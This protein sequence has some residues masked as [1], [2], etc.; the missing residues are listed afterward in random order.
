MAAQIPTTAR[1]Y[2][3]PALGSYT[4]LTLQTTPLPALKST[5]VLVKIHAVS[6]Q[7]RDLMIALNRY[8]HGNLPENLV[9][10]SDMAGEVV[11]VG[12]DVTRW[13]VGDRVCANFATDHLDGDV[14]A[15]TTKSALGGGQ[16][17]VLT[18]YRSFPDN[19][20][21]K[22]PGHLSFEEAST[23]PCAALTAYN[24]LM[25]PKPVKA[26]DTVLVL[27]TGGVSIF[28]LQFAV[29]SGANVIAT[30]SSDDKLEIAKK[31]GATHT[32]NYNTTPDWDKGRR[33]VDHILEVGG[34]G[35][36][37]KSLASVRYAGYI[38]IIGSVSKN[39]STLTSVIGPCIGKAI[40]LRGIRVGS[41]AQFESMNRLLRARPEP[42]RPAVDRVFSFEE[43]V[44]AY[45]Y[46]ESQ[47]HVGKVV[48]RRIPGYGFAR[49]VMVLM[50]NGVNPET[51]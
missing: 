44:D 26:G 19:S 25:G 1:S 35:T 30:S 3:F 47:K 40:I 36:F 6:L 7:F 50:W 12:S 14:N 24:A 8:S 45:A 37:E 43:A 33:G 38:H 27:G 11:A 39:A 31:L 16:H 2:Y 34:P 20:L 13:E 9:P 5:Y 46:L 10:C 29:A 51:E 4:N 28:G 22:I 21:V 49:W 41:V 48:I 32:I 15:E 23:L 18:D 17:G 42:T